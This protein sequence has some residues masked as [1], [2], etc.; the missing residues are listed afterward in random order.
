MIDSHGV[1][2]IPAPTDPTLTEAEEA[3]L[4]FITFYEE[5]CAAHEPRSNAVL[6]RWAALY[7]HYQRQH[8]Q[9]ALRGLL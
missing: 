8:Q 6:D 9:L 1:E 2:H 7:S 4:N 3:Q 5:V